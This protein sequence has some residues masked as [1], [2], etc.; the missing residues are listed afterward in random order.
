MYKTRLK[1]ADIKEIQSKIPYMELDENIIGIVKLLNS[2]DDIYTVGS[3]G[4][5]K[6]N[7]SFQCPEGEWSVIFKVNQSK[8]GWI[9]LEFLVWIIN[10]SLRHDNYHLEIVPCAPPPFVNG[11]LGSCI[12]FVLE[13]RNISP[14]QLT[15]DINRIKNEFYKE[16]VFTLTNLKLKSK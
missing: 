4:G 12:Y 10:N 2:F 1:K 7:K 5:H 16:S 9:S 8:S 3:C 13:G 15:E 11:E 6:D 14:S